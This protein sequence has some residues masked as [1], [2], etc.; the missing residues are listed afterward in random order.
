MLIFF[1][2][3][4]VICIMMLERMS[5]SKSPASI[6]ETVEGVLLRVYV[7]PRSANL[8]FVFEEEEILVFCRENPVKGKVNREIIK[9]LTKLFHKRVKLLAGSTSR[10][11]MFLIVDAK[12]DQVERFLNGC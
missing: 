10:Q 2:G 8:G 1:I 6:E 9:E 3:V 11:K 12:K 7:K 4:N 5:R